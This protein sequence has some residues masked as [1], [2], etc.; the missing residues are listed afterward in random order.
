MIQ[1][2]VAPTIRFEAEPHKYYQEP[3]GEEIPGITG[4]L[5]DVG[6]ID[7]SMVR[8]DVLAAAAEFGTHVHHA[9]HYHEDGELDDQTLTE[10]VHGCLMGY[11]GF[12]NQCRF[13]VHAV[14]TLVWSPTHR[15]ATMIDLIGSL[16][17]HPAVVNVKTGDRLA[18]H[19]VQLAA[20]VATLPD[21]RKYRRI[22]LKLNRD[23]TYKVYE[24]P[25]HDYGRDLNVFHAAAALWHWKH[26]NGRR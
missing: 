4:V 17:G 20:E 12:K 21:A 26:D 18:W 5:K 3:S 11:L 25:A 22:G 15:Y 2:A 23:G 14:E 13:E 6:I 9:V 10:D 1:P 16:D 8:P 24:Y 7:F 19:A